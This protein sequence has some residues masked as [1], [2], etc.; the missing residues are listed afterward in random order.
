LLNIGSPNS[1]LKLGSWGAAPPLLISHPPKPSPTKN[2]EGSEEEKGFGENPHE[3]TEI[4]RCAAV[5]IEVH[6]TTRKK[7]M[8]Q[9]P[10]L[11]TAEE[12]ADILNIGRSTVFKLMKQNRL[13]SIR[14]GRS[15]RVPLDALQNLIG[16]LRHGYTE[17]QLF[18][19]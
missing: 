16:D 4:C 2:P 8:T 10:I 3:F 18:D 1:W 7:A 14:L 9:L 11:Y 5:T 13:E 15:R 17:K 12:V 6:I 19:D